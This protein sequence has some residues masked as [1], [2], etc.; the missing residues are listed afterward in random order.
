MLNQSRLMQTQT[1]GM[2]MRTSRVLVAALAVVG[3]LAAGTAVLAQSLQRFPDVAPGHYAFEAVEWAAEVGVTTG[4]TDGTF[5]PERPLS[6][7]HA[8]VFME[9]YYDKI[10]Q[11]EE[12]EDFTRGDMMVLLKAI[13]DGTIRGTESDTAAGSVSE[14]GA[15]Q[16]FPD[17]AP[18]HYAFE[19]VEWAAEVGVT[20]GYTDGTF[21]PER[22]LSKQH[23]VVFMERYYDEI[24]QAEES[25]DFARGDMMVL[26][27]AINDGTI[28]GA[29]RSDEPRAHNVM[30]RV[31]VVRPDWHSFDVRGGWPA[32]LETRESDSLK[33][34]EVAIW[35]EIAAIH[36]Y[37]FDNDFDPFRWDIADSDLA[38]LT[39]QREGY[40]IQRNPGLPEPWS[41][42]RSEFIRQAFASFTADI[43]SRY[44]ESAHHLV[45]NGHGAP[46]GALF[47][48]QLS[49]DDAGGLLA[50]WTSQLGRRLGVI[51]MG[52][53]CNKGSFSDLENFCEYAQYYVASDLLNGG[54]RLDDWTLEKS[55]ATNPDIQ[56]HRLFA[57]SR[58]LREALIGR[59][60]I[61]R[62]RYSD[63]RVDMTTNRIKQANYLYSCEDF[64]DF[65]L[66]F[67]MFLYDNAG[68]DRN[69]LPDLYSFMDR[70]N[71]SEELLR[72]FD[73]VF[74]HR[75]DNRDFFEWDG[76]YNGM[77]MPT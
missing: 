10:L 18:G 75:A 1:G 70:H 63:S 6:K 16:R 33:Y 77:L 30:V 34:F 35:E 69:G 54:Y 37:E 67:R 40:V 4:Y 23:A 20:T 43:V 9:R 13:S 5:K 66:V 29:V 41:V 47:E 25:E 50:H 51:D 44:P 38:A 74:V 73:G 19:A 36:F 12:S 68:A 60:D 64:L 58:D 48:A 45:Y 27:K 65:S 62:E 56:Y 57:D 28:R 14:Q 21:K 72:A 52:G 46:G 8:V 7:Q 2:A 61:M 42:E 49:Y 15:S 22:P 53:P 11:A 76:D 32:A 59:I 17:V 26:L 55:Q 3:V 24:L 31:V 71:A 39:A